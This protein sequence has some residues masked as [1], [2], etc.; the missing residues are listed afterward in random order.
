MRSNQTGLRGAPIAPRGAASNPRGLISLMPSDPDRVG[1]KTAVRG[2]RTAVCQPP[3]PFCSSSWGVQTAVL[4]ALFAP[5]PPS[6]AG[7]ML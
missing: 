5:E 4:W 2:G 7:V 3:K 1:K 6:S